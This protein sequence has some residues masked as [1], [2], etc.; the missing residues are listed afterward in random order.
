M[1]KI[2][3]E[4]GILNQLKKTERPAVPEGFFDQLND[5][6]GSEMDTVDIESPIL[7]QLGKAKKPEVEKSFF[8]RY[9][10]SLLTVG[11]NL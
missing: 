5:S 10:K 4:N 9:F 6:L 2:Q 8:I 7:D 1:Q 3:S 11:V